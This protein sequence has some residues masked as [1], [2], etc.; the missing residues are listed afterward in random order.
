MHTRRH[1]ETLYCK[2]GTRLYKTQ[3]TVGEHGECSKCARKS[4]V[5]TKPL[6][7]RKKKK[8]KVCSKCG[9][10]IRKEQYDNKLCLKCRKDAMAN[11]AAVK[12]DGNWLSMVNIMSLK[13]L[14]VEG[15]E[16]EGGCKKFFNWF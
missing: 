4:T 14:K 6:R 13:P 5:T 7:S 3:A 10:R 2:C 8:F 9:S 15:I 16:I 12:H 11:C 1:P